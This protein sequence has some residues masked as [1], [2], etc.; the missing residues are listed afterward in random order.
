[1]ELEKGL[2]SDQLATFTALKDYGE[3]VAD[4][5]RDGCLTKNNP[6]LATSAYQ[7][8]YYCREVTLAIT[9]L[10]F[11]HLNKGKDHAQARKIA[12]ALGLDVNSPT[13]LLWREVFDKAHATMHLKSAADRTKPGDSFDQT[14]ESFEF[15]LGE[16]VATTQA[17]VSAVR[18]IARKPASYCD[19]GA[20]EN[21]M[22]LPVCKQTFFDNLSDPEWLHVL[23]ARDYFHPNTV[24]RLFTENG[25]SYLPLW[26]PSRYL[27]KAAANCDKRSYRELEKILIELTQAGKDGTLTNY[28][29]WHA[30]QEVLGKLPVIHISPALI[31]CVGF[32]LES[33]ERFLIGY[34]LVREVLPKFFTSESDEASITLGDQLL[35]IVLTTAPNPDYPFDRSEGLPTSDAVKPVI[36]LGV[37][38]DLYASKPEAMIVMASRLPVETMFFIADQIKSAFGKDLSGWT[39]SF[40]SLSDQSARFSTEEVKSQFSLLLASLLEK[41]PESRGEVI[42]ALTSAFLDERH[43]PQNVFRMLALVLIRTHWVV[44][45][46]LFFTFITTSGFWAYGQDN[47]LRSVLKE[48]SP[49]LLDAE[50]SRLQAIIDAGPPTPA[51]GA[52][53]HWPQHVEHLKL[54]MYSA[55][56]ESP[57]FKSLHAALV[58]KVGH[59]YKE[60]SGSVVQARGISS[61]LAVEHMMEI[62]NEEIASAMVTFVPKDRWVEPSIDGLANAFRS[63]VRKNPMKFLV[64]SRPFLQIFYPYAYHLFDGLRG[65]FT[66]GQRF[67][68]EAALDFALQYVS[69]VSFGTD[70]LKAPTDDSRADHKWIVGELGYFLSDVTRHDNPALTL[71]AVESA[72][73]L[74]NKLIP[75]LAPAPIEDYQ[76]SNMDYP[77]HAINTT[78]GKILRAF[79]DVQLKRGRMTDTGNKAGPVRWDAGS[80]NVFEGAVSQ[81]ILEAHVLIGWYSPHFMFLD[82]SWTSSMMVKLIEAD[83]HLW[84]GF[85]AGFLFSGVAASEVV[86]TLMKPHFYRAVDERYYPTSITGRRFDHY[87]L[88]FYGLSLEGLDNDSLIGRTLASKDLKRLTDMVAGFHVAGRELDLET[89][90][91][92]SNRVLDFWETVSAMAIKLP[93]G[94]ERDTLLRD[95]NLLI[96]FVVKLDERERTLITKSSKFVPPQID[97]RYLMELEHLLRRQPSVNSCLF[98]GSLASTLIFKETAFFFSGRLL[99]PIVATLYKTGD[100]DAKRIANQI[101]NKLLGFGYDNLK[102]LYATHN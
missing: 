53:E 37:L 95:L 92:F 27:A 91:L 76:E 56:K 83:S 36:Y 65:A 70:T 15:I 69:Q 16:F 89:K 96:C 21:L 20:L 66:D 71:Q 9:R 97:H 35:K 22:Q 100:R 73:Q 13:A 58:E 26:E 40:Q 45:K 42:R 18:G 82:S 102:E 77:T 79:L 93:E 74:I 23:F 5:F 80:A 88:G 3:V 90:T 12:E 78:S 8:A 55:L 6:T 75:Y 72:Q 68:L 94:K 4:F 32:W 14:W 1:M 19:W 47:D 41:I 63:A 46:D 11:E 2:R 67:D 50:C 28:R 99:A 39:L 52:D 30:C 51:A 34:E 86:Y 60:S 7:L 43:Y 10:T 17:K 84:K 24:G 25:Q 61:P 54:R 62:S 64:D 81:G 31:E 98:I 49:H 29:V 57:H 101:H 33:S 85:F 44:V 38:D 87:V 59:D 48:L